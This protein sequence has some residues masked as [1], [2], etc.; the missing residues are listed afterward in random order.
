MVLPP[1]SITTVAPAVITRVSL[2]V[3]VPVRVKVL[4]PKIKP[5]SGKPQAAFAFWV[6]CRA[7]VPPLPM[8]PVQA[9]MLL[10]TTIV[11]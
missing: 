9:G 6:Y 2:S 1:P 10:G 5:P 3:Q 8:A 4:L 11:P 7:L